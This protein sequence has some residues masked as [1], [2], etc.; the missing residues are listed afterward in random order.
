[1]ASCDFYSAFCRYVV[2][3]KILCTPYPFV[4]ATFSGLLQAFR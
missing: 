1:M 3:I 4:A 2:L